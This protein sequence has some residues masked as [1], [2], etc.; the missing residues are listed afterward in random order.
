MGDGTGI[1]CV[2]GLT[3]MQRRREGEMSSSQVG[4]ELART[5]RAS[6]VEQEEGSSSLAP[7]H[8]R[9][10]Q[11]RLGLCVGSRLIKSPSANGE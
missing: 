4:N 5:G 1:E 3:A 9:A 2:R 10:E 11:S 6:S 8:S 7:L